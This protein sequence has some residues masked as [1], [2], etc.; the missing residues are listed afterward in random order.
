MDVRR[1][2]EVAIHE[3]L[4]HPSVRPSHMSLQPPVLY[5]I[6]EGPMGLRCSDTARRCP[7]SQNY[8]SDSGAL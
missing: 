3:P 4:L 1:P 2:C 7:E 6:L 8:H 5:S